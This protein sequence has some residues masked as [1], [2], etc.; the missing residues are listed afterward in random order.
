MSPRR[1]GERG[2]ASLEL[3]GILPLALVFAVLALQVGGF[4][5]AIT[6][7]NEAVRDGARAQSLGL[8][9]CAAARDSLTDTLKVTSCNAGGT[10]SVRLSVEVPILPV[11]DNLV[12]DVTVTR[13][14]HLP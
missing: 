3:M 1:F 5:W 7:T 9:G 10:G 4:L 6:S 14:A 11:V 8:P 12:P 13:E 2:S